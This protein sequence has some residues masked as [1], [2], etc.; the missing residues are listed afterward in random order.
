MHITKILQKWRVKHKQKKWHKKSRYFNT[1]TIIRCA[2]HSKIS[3]MQNTLYTKLKWKHDKC[4]KMHL[5]LNKVTPKRAC[6]V[7]TL[8]S[9]CLLCPFFCHFFSLYEQ[10]YAFWRWQKNRLKRTSSCDMSICAYTMCL[11]IFKQGWNEKL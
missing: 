6:I 11:N 1:L 5:N 10:A 3:S 9:V 8:H 2:K 4:I 7:N